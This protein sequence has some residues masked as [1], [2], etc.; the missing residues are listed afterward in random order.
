MIEN[1]QEEPIKLKSANFEA[2]KDGE[3]K[4][5][6]KP[7]PKSQS[8]DT[9]SAFSCQYTVGSEACKGCQWCSKNAAWG[10]GNRVI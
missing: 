9:Y 4:A 8:F 1:N 5:T 6:A 7:I 10:T 2:S 3:Q